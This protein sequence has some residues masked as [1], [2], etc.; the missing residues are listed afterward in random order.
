MGVAADLV[1]CNRD[2]KESA[3]FA[4]KQSAVP[5]LR[6]SSARARFL[7]TADISPTP[8]LAASVARASAAS[9]AFVPAAVEETRDEGAE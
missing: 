3:A 2:L 5:F 1:A 6:C 7:S 4:P 9:L 8:R